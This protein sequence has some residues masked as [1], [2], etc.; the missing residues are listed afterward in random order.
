MMDDLSGMICDTVRVMPK[1]RGMSGGDNIRSLET[2]WSTWAEKADIGDPL[3]VDGQDV[4]SG[5][6]LSC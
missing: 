1:H 2:G 6:N 4:T 3:A 5:N